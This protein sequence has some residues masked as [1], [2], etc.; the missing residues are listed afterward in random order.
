MERPAVER[1]QQCC[2][3]QFRRYNDT[4]SKDI[5]PGGR[6]RRVPV[7]PARGGQQVERVFDERSGMRDVWK[8]MLP[9]LC[10]HASLHP[11]RAITRGSRMK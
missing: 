7:D 6:Y 5:S 3:K 1:Q 11:A 9:Y 4:A 10:V 8:R 2:A